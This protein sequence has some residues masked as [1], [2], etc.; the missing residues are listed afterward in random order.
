MTS[1]LG[2]FELPPPKDWQKFERL[3]RDL[4]AS[5]WGDP[6]AQANGRSG[7]AQAGVDVFGRRAG[8]AAYS[9]VQCK[10]RSTTPDGSPIT[11]DELRAE[12]EK[13]KTFEPVLGDE[14]VLASTG[15]RDAKIQ[16]V[17][18]RI[19]EEHAA[20]GLFQVYVYSWDDI[21]DS[22][23]AHPEVIARHYPM[24]VTGGT[25]QTEQPGTIATPF[26]GPAKRQPAVQSTASAKPRPYVNWENF[27]VLPTED[28]ARSAT[29]L[30]MVAVPD[31][32]CPV[33]IDGPT[34]AAFKRA[35]EQCFNQEVG[36]PSTPPYSYCHDLV[37]RNYA[38]TV[39]RH[40]R[41][42]IDG[43][44]GFACTIES[45]YR[46]GHVS[47]WETAI[48][49]LTFLSFLQG[50]LNRD[51]RLELD[52]QPQQLRPTPAP[53]APADERKTP[54]A[55]LP[56]LRSADPY[57]LFHSVE[58]HLTQ[59]ELAKPSPKLAAML[60]ARW[61]VMFNARMIDSGSLARHLERLLE[62]EVLQAR[63]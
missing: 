51:L 11:E 12:V 40:W 7:Q 32:S 8:R 5:L 20:L 30:K 3:C 60:T 22:L 2:D 6:N 21:Q 24:H 54:L 29:F 26:A 47:L 53:L 52:F 43:S 48:D 17:A 44:L 58:E 34:F 13:A 27:Y 14:F 28:G 23:N 36:E 56:S 35:V 59:S 9:G 38:G 18:R 19:S 25:K 31:L 1:G 37:C 39:A 16:A 33:T 61:R 4:W 10:K 49:C 63:R 55:G 62:L 50:N 41:Q 46:P 15:R 57:S 45:A 42:G